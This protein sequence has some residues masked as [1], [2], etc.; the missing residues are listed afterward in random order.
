MNVQNKLYSQA[1]FKTTL[2]PSV[3]FIG[4][5]P[6]Y[7]TESLKLEKISKV[8]QANHPPTTNISN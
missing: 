7:I 2:V 4:L 5:Y 1:E 3:G 6:K 8:I